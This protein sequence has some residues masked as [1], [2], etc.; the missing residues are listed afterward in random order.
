[1]TTPTATVNRRPNPVNKKRLNA[2]VD[3]ILARLEAERQAAA[4]AETTGSRA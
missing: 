1:M 3:R 4:E 2:L